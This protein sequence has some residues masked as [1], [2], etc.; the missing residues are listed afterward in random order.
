VSRRIEGNTRIA[1]DL[2]VPGLIAI[3]ISLAVF[4]FLGVRYLKRLCA[5]LGKKKA[6]IVVVFLWASL[7]SVVVIREYYL[8]YQ[9]PRAMDPNYRVAFAPTYSMFLPRLYGLDYVTILVMS[10]LAGFAIREID[11]VLFGFL[12][13]VLLLFVIAVAYTSLFI[14]YVLGFGAVLDASFATTI[15][16]AAF[17]NIYRMVFPLAVLAAFLGGISGSII[18]D[19]VNP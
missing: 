6:A 16:W 4:L 9:D 12:A 1:W 15:I 13:S 18:R 7:L 3:A 14:W 10:I 11:E 5:W 8:V 2:I 19:F 17:L